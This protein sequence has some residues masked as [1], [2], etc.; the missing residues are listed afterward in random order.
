M[1]NQISRRVLALAYGVVAWTA[2]GTEPVE[3]HLQTCAAREADCNKIPG[4]AWYADSQG[5]CI[6]TKI[7]WHYECWVL[8]G[9]AWSLQGEGDC[10]TNTN[11]YQ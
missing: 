8:E 5:T 7:H 4:G 1:Q 9:G 10:D 3:A 11:C 2:A 6:H